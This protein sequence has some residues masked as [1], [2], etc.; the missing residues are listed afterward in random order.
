MKNRKIYSLIA[1]LLIFVMVLGFVSC[2]DTTAL[3]GDTNGGTNSGDTAGDGNLT[4]GGVGNMIGRPNGGTVSSGSGSGESSGAIGSDGNAGSVPGNS[5]EAYPGGAGMTFVTDIRIEN[6]FIIATM[7]DGTEKNIGAA[8][9]NITENNVT[10]N[11]TAFDATAFAAS[12]ALLST[13]GIECA[14]T[15]LENDYFGYQQRETIAYASGSGVIYS[16]DKTTGDAYIIT[17]YHVVYE[18]RSIDPGQISR[19]IK[20]YML[21]DSEKTDATFVGGSPK[22]DIAVLKVTGSAR[23]AASAAAVVDVADD[24]ARAGESILVVGNARGEGIAVTKGIVSVDSEYI[25]MDSLTDYGVKETSRVIR[26]DAPVNPGNS[27]G[28]LFDASGRLLGIINAKQVDEE[29][30]GMGYAIPVG[31]ALT[32]VEKVIAGDM[33][34][35]LVTRRV[36]MGVTLTIADSSMVY[37]TATGLISIK[38]KVV[39]AED[40]EAEGID[41][42]TAGGLGEKAGLMCGDVITAICVGDGDIRV[43]T[44]QHHIIDEVLKA[45]AGDSISITVLRDID[46]TITEVNCTVVVPTDYYGA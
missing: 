40:N 30:E 18:A 4:D 43:V 33:D 21:G 26:I 8:S 16:V 5:G 17:N 32:I 27:G 41:G 15:V 22:Y 3:P 1:C 9:A 20:V 25:T 11:G 38:E 36:L 46:G 14:F 6:G 12:K 35:E 44:R 7:S 31:I 2:G 37:D 13:V 45:R 39:I 28:G 29:T 24:E 19:N 23:F 10:V 42:I 34:E